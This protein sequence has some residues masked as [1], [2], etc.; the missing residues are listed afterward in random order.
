MLVLATGAF[1]EEIIFFHIFFN[2]R[3]DIVVIEIM[4]VFGWIPAAAVIVKGL[5]EVWQDY[6]QE[7]YQSKI[8][9]SVLAIDV[10]KMTEQ[11]PKSLENIFASLHGACSTIL[12]KENWFDG[13]VQPKFSFEIASIDGFIQFYVRCETRHRDIVEAGFY[14]QY[15]DAQITEVEDYMMR[16]PSRFPDSE[17]NM[18]GAEMIIESKHGDFVPFKTWQNFEHKMSQELKDPLAVMLEQISRMRPGECFIIQIL[19]EVCSQKWKEAGEKFIKKTYGLK[20]DSKGSGIIDDLLKIPSEMVS[21]VTGI[22]LGGGVEEKKDEDIWRA[23]KITIS[24][25]AMVEAVANKISQIGLKT[26]IRLVY[27]AKKEVFAKYLRVPMIKGMLVQYNNPGGAEFKMSSRSIPKGDYFWQRWLY[28]QRQSRL[29]QA[30]KKRHVNMGATPR[31]LCA[32]ELATLYHFP[33]ILVKA[34]LV[35]KTESRRAEPP[36]S[37]PIASEDTPLYRSAP[38]AFISSSRKGAPPISLSTS[39]EGKSSA[40]SAEQSLF[41]EPDL[42]LTPPIGFPKI[43]NKKIIGVPV[44]PSTV[45]K[46]P[47]AMRVLLDPNVELEEVN[48]PTVPG[49]AE[50]VDEKEKNF[51]PPNLPI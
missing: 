49:E 7:I 33:S 42:Q 38:P 22:D 40:I 50:A 51:V 34:P 36:V 29:S 14:A 24:E 43:S 31:V 32:E 2:Q 10:P 39:P 48:L 3:F 5:L 16:F 1:A 44:A 20:E 26:K 8:K 12:W 23:F 47:D 13:K 6:R 46:I 4:M 45:K 21:H 30:L 11:S 25:K 18:W 28:A 35:K 17:W 37:L 27:Y 15:P 9:W 19:T 41:L